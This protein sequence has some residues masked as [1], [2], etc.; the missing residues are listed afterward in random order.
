MT[1]QVLP[2]RN[3]S[4]CTLC[5]KLLGVEEI[6]TP[7]LGWCPH[8][9]TRRGCQIYA[10][11]PTECRQFDCEYLSNSA[12][13]EHW[14]PSRCK[15]VVALEEHANALVIYV[16]PSRPHAWRHE[17]FYSEIRQWAR[18]AA[19]QQRDVVVWQGDRKILISPEGDDDRPRAAPKPVDAGAVT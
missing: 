19:R 2:S 15:M 4:G 17:P 3:C 7:P 14:R 9:D 5:C 11:R 13:G 18:T 12:L 1:R 10:R 6:E 16:D 8:C